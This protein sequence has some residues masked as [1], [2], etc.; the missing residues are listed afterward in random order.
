MLIIAN[1]EKNPTLTLMLVKD[2]EYW[3]EYN[4]KRKEYIQE[5]EL[6]INRLKE[7]LKERSKFEE[8]NKEW[9]QKYRELENSNQNQS[10]YQTQV[11][12]LADKHLN[13]KS[14]QRV[15][16]SQEVQEREFLKSLYDKVWNLV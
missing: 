1:C 12:N 7:E 9:E 8:R 4:Q 14:I 10:N 15:F 6:T 5:L 16:S 3:K 2:K 13:F 11:L